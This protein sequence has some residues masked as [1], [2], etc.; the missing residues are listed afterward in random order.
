MPDGCVD[1]VLTDPPYQI[2]YKTSRRKDKNHRFCTEIFNDAN[3]D[4]L[5]MYLCECY[6]ILKKDRAAYVFCSPKTVDLL[7]SI[8]KRIGFSIKNR[9]VW[10]KNNW[11]A[12]DLRCQFGQQYELILLLNK[13]RAPFRGKRIS[14][15]WQFSRVPTNELVHQNQKPIDMLMQCLEKHSDIGD[16]VFDGCMGAGSV[17]VAC[18]QSGREFFGVEIDEGYFAIAKDRIYRAQQYNGQ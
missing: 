11:T 8:C 2:G 9:I 10:V 12:G 7:T 13:G 14:D 17:G 6:R 4:F 15:V 5:E 1:L 18:V 16:L 3:V